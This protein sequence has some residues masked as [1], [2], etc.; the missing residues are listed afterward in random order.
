VCTGWN[1]TGSVPASGTNA[2]TNISI[3]E[4]SSV[5]WDWETQYHVYV[6]TDP[7]G[8]NPQPSV[9]SVG[10]WY[11]EGAV[12]T[13]TAQN[14]SG[15]V[16]GH[17]TAGGSSYEVGLNPINIT[18]YGPLTAT[19]HYLPAPTWWNNLLAP[20]NMPIVVALF[21]VLIG[22]MIGGAWFGVRRKRINKARPEARP[23][24]PVVVPK[25][26]L[27]GRIPT[28]SE[29]LDNLLH[30]G[31]PQGYSVALTSPS[32]DERGSLIKRFLEAGAKKGDVTFLVTI[33]P[34]ELTS[35]AEEQPNFYLFVCNPQADA[36][37]KSASNVFKLKGVE[38]LTDISIALTS[39]IRRLDPSLTG[40]RR[41]C[42]GLVSDVLLQ[43]QTVQTRRW[44]AGLIPELRSAGFTTLAVLDP[45]M[46]A[47]QET[48]A[49][50]DLFEG[51]I[52]ISEI[53]T[54]KGPL[55]FIKVKKMASQKYSEQESILKKE[56]VETQNTEKKQ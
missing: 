24:A 5:T 10:P 47:P 12:L 49:I 35:L 46:H 18:V 22:S 25:I 30:G 56:S 33:D 40:S 14:V 19:A 31:I 7:A 51:E 43:H 29:D 9:S 13:C 2:S 42:I 16:F 6:N 36:I 17:W 48:R 54:G 23:E 52:N 34:G 3:T 53:D 15:K 41:I 26:V 45:E 21:V 32:C 8:L 39:A 44:L 37:I 28:G 20:Q 55:K 1:G 11:D 50:L 27:P 38:N 4:P